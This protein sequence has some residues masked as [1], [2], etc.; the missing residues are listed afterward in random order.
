M[1]AGSRD[2]SGGGWYQCHTLASHP[3][4]PPGVTTGDGGERPVGTRGFGAGIYR[5]YGALFGQR[6]RAGT[7]AMPKWLI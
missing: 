6:E 2:P 4:I 5:G 1:A 3:S 7:G